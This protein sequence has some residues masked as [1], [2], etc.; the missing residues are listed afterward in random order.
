MTFAQLRTLVAVAEE[1]SVRRAARRLVV[2]EPAVSAAM[3]ALGREVGQ[4]LIAREGR[5]VR[6]T[7]AGRTLAG[8]AAEILGLAEQA[9]RELETSGP[10][11]LAAVTT[12]GE[13]VLPPILKAFRGRHPEIEVSLEVGNRA[14]VFDALE[15]H[16]VELAVTGQPPS[17]RALTGIPFLDHRLVVVAAP[18]TVAGDLEAATWLLRERGSGT[19]ETV[20]RF[21]VAAGIEPRSTMTLGS[22]GAVKQAAA[23]GLGV[24][25][26]S[27]QATAAEVA[28][29]SL[30]R[31]D[32]PGTPIERRWYAVAP[33]HGPET[34]AAIRFRAFCLSD[35]ARRAVAAAAPQ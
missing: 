35:G 1:G 2:T 11:R 17:G 24:T 29:G 15:H 25:L 16:Q 3:S 8:Y 7:P 31:V 20:E 19:R 9:R 5:G 23:V 22:N 32:V 26:L 21:L 4:R 6:L 34:A 14:T 28:A 13:Y 33:A 18:G 30:V 10:L 12:A 27:E